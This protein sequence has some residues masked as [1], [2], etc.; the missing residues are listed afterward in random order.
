MPLQRRHVLLL[1][2]LAHRLASGTT[3]DMATAAEG[4]RHG[5]PPPQGL[6]GPIDLIDQTG[7]RFTLAQLAGR[8]A[9]LFF[10]LLHCGSTCP[11]ALATA[12][13]LLAMAPVMSAPAVV[14]ITLDPLS[15]TPRSLGDTLG[16][17]DRRLIGLTGDPVRVDA[18]AQRYGV[19]MARRADGMDHSSMWYL[20]DGGGAVRRVYGHTTSASHLLEDLR[21]VQS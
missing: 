19:G 2:L 15:D 21:R 4:L 17:I 1:P 9:L 10:G 20:L 16:A 6:G 14:F 11:V 12:R 8:P 18:V 13:Q 7:R 3:R 5:Q